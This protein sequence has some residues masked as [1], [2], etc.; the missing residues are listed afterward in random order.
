MKK[1]EN[2][3]YEFL[4]A[5]YSN[6]N[7]YKLEDI[8]LIVEFCGLEKEDEKIKDDESVRL[9]L[10]DRLFQ[11]DNGYYSNNKNIDFGMSKEEL[12]LASNDDFKDL[13]DGARSGLRNIL[14]TFKK[15]VKEETLDDIRDSIDFQIF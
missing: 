11:L 5:I 9:M 12:T 4:K 8:K 2:F 13:K 3:K 1:D 10:E 15:E 14:S 6:D 7:V